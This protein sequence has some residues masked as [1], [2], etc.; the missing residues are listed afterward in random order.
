MKG[1]HGAI[2]PSL[3]GKGRTIVYKLHG[4]SEIRFLPSRKLVDAEK[5]ANSFPVA[6]TMLRPRKDVIVE[7]RGEIGTLLVGLPK[8]SRL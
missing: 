8:G 5:A 3:T 4:T 2:P 1:K 7:A 6:C